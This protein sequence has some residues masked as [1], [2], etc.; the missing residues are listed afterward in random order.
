MF[1]IRKLEQKDK[2]NGLKFTIVTPISIK[3]Q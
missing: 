3:S 2:K 1:M